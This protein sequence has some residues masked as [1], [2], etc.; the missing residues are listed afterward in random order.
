MYLVVAA[1]ALAASTVFR[2]LAAAT[3]QVRYRSVIWYR[4]AQQGSF[5]ALCRQHVQEAR[6]P[7]GVIAS[8]I[9]CSGFDTH[10]IF[11]HKVSHS[12]VLRDQQNP[13]P[14]IPTGTVL[15]SGNTQNLWPAH[16]SNRLLYY[17]EFNWLKSIAEEGFFSPRSHWTRRLLLFVL[18]QRNIRMLPSW[19]CLLHSSKTSR[20]ER[21][22]F[23]EYLLLML[24]RYSSWL[25]QDDKK[26]NNKRNLGRFAWWF[27]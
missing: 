5:K 14:L 17:F 10:T 27:V 4:S 9:F 1:S 6:R 21:S 12:S 11:A 16:N 13:D 26:S 8:R 20:H 23:Q 15:Y 22:S 7:L 24:E 25:Q 18:L 19:H 2:S 3:F